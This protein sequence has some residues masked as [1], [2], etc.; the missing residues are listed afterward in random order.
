VDTHANRPDDATGTQK[1]LAGERA[2]RLEAMQ[3][4]VA[5]MEAHYSRLTNQPDL[6]EIW[7]FHQHLVL[8][9]SQRGRSE[10]TRK[11]TVIY[12]NPD[13]EL[14][15]PGCGGTPGNEDLGPWQSHMA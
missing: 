14:E 11:F 6:R 5:D 2:Y 9:P 13:L 15:G 3:H 4:V 12:P 10:V 1:F 7:A 8:A